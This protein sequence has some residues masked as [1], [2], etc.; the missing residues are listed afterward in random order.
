MALPGIRTT[1][2]DRFYNQSRTDLPSGPI[3]AIIAKRNTND[4]STDSPN[5]MPYYASS[6]QD[7][8]TQYGE[9]SY[10][11][12]AFYEV[13]TAGASRIVLIPLPSDTVFNHSATSTLTAL[14]SASY[15]GFNLFDE[16]FSGVEV[17]QADIVVPWGRGTDTTDWDDHATPA[18][19]GNQTTDFFYADN[20]SVANT[21]WAKR[22]ADKCADITYDSHP[23][24][25][26]MGVKG[27]SGPETPTPS[28]V[29]SGIAFTNLIAKDS[30]TNGH[31]LNVVAAEVHP[32]GAPTAWGMSNGAC[33]YAASIARLDA[34]SAPT[35]KPVFNVDAYRYKLNRTQANS[36]ITLGVVTTLRDFEGALRWAD[37]PTFAPTDS[38]YA[39][40]STLR[41]VF[42]AV[43]LV[44]KVAQNYIG[45]GM[46]LQLRNALDT[47]ISSGLRMMQQMGAINNADFT[48]EYAP[49]LN[50][51]TVHL[52]IVPASELREIYTNISVTF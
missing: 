27:I 46:N 50:K 32:L 4:A 20:S 40:L 33:A 7:V 3:I 45:E 16:V 34:W 14:T 30:V 11:H 42:D 17:S 24:I 52:A 39:R 49:S 38:D 19:T 37:A 51:A 25:A 15:G 23:V 13:T 22:V 35:N 12:R 31:F 5:F 28:T 36:V 6:E 29:T 26:V 47:Q 1:I 44:R 48:V 9:D 10:L 8:I 21:S 41:I 18:A 2:L 43:K